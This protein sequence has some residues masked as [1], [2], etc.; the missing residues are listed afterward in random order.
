M[1][2]TSKLATRSTAPPAVISARGVVSA[3]RALSAESPRSI[4]VHRWLAATAT[5]DAAAAALAV[6]LGLVL[7]FGDAAQSVVGLPAPVLVAAVAASWCLGLLSCGAYDARLLGTGTA[8]FQRVVA[9]GPWLLVATLLVSYASHREVPRGV[10]VITVPLVVLL[11]LLLRAVVRWRLRRRMA[12]GGAL[13]R[14]VVAGSRR[15][16][17]DFLRHLDRTPGCGVVVVGAC[18]GDGGD[19]LRSGGREVALLG[20]LE[21]MA[22][23]S[24]QAGADMVV[25]AGSAALSGRE[26]HR[27]SWQLEGSGVR[28][29]VAP[30]IAD[31]AGPRIGVH[32]VNGL[33]LMYVEEPRFSGVHRVVKAVI[34]RLAAGLLLL[35]LAPL[36]AVLVLVI[37]LSSPGPAF[38]VQ[39][40]IGLHGK[41]FAM[42]KLRTMR[43]GAAREQARLAVLNEADGPLFKIRSDPRVTAVGGFLRRFSLDELPQ[44]WNVLRGDMSLVGPRPPLAE[45]VDRY[46]RDARRRL[47]VKPGITGLWQISGRSD[48]SWD[49]SVRLDLHYVENWSVMLDLTVLARTLIAVVSARGAY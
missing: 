20:D 19:G 30:A 40:R 23:V 29:V 14:A 44:L 12:R 9:A 22:E 45:E 26:L 13:H 48:L 27:L 34:D 7:R 47:L 38:F 37:R 4:A 3:R 16:V 31:L 11:S 21:D 5:A 32:A 25:V 1:L 2:T 36:L 6:V 35:L 17:V 15:D 28:L 41:P 39:Q 8:E 46:P 42:Y 49:E 24:Q 10:T 33:P 18:V 43:A